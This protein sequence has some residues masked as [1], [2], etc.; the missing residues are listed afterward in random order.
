MVEAI[1]AGDAER[2]RLVMQQH[3]DATASMLRGFLGS[4]P[5]RPASRR[6]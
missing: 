3:I 5:S 2:A 1:L 6:R 4:P